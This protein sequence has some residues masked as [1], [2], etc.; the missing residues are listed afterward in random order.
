[1]SLPEAKYRLEFLSGVLE[2]LRSWAS[3]AAGYG[4]GPD[5]ADV[6]EEFRVELTMNPTAWGDPAFNFSALKLVIYR[7]Y[8]RILQV[9]YAVHETETVVIV[10]S[11]VLTRGTM[12]Y[13]L[14]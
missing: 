4:M 2:Q 3:T 9:E 11:V 7:R 5:F 12:P 10:R 13:D 8:G 6:L 1:M 14:W